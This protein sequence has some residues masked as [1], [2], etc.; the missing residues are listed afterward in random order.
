[1]SFIPAS[2]QLWN[3]SCAVVG[4]RQAY[5]LAPARKVSAKARGPLLGPEMTAIEMLR[6][7]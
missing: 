3:P 6:C 5:A 1:M 7:C 4:L 2:F